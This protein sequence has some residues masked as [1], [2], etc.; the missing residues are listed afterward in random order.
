MSCHHK[1]IHFDYY[2]IVCEIL[3]FTDPYDIS[4]LSL[5]GEYLSGFQ[6]FTIVNNGS[7]KFSWLCVLVYMLN[8][9]YEW[10]C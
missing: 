9:T 8:Y 4:N 2:V 6:V 1:L 10:N 5:I 7:S 3:P